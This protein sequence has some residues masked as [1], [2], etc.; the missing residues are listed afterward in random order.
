MFL[1]NSS[2]LLLHGCPI[3]FFLGLLWIALSYFCV[4]EGLRCTVKFL[5]LLTGAWSQ[6]LRAVLCGLT[7]SGPSSHDSPRLCSYSV[8]NHWRR[9]WQPTPVFMPGKFLG[10]R[11]LE[12][13]N[14][15]GCKQS[16]TTKPIGQGLQQ[17]FQNMVP[18]LSLPQPPPCFSAPL[19]LN[20]YLP[21]PLPL[22]LSF[23]S[24]GR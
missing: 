7:M 13:Y 23:C 5:I 19:C 21:V 4:W 10:Q 3:L 15:W 6:C 1:L 17:S 22:S 20:F 8:F 9:K 24:E 14:P 12:G 11:N 16:D 18:S 2:L